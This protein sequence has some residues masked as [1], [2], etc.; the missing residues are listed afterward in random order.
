MA[1]Q[2]FSYNGEK[3]NGRFHGRGVWKCN[4]TQNCYDGEFY[5]GTFHGEGR[6]V[7]TG[8]GEVITGR[9]VDGQLNGTV[10]VAFQNNNKLERRLYQQGT[11]ISSA[12][13]RNKPTKSA[14]K[15]R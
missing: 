9:W 15:T 8:T 12:P 3:L 5:K 4:I 14:A 2:L 1:A 10:I 7:N 13:A 11:L 6:L